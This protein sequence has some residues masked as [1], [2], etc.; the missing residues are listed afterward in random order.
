MHDHDTKRLERAASIVQENLKQLVDFEEL[1]PIW[2]RPGWT[3][4]AEFLLVE[5]M[6]NSLVALS[7]QMLEMKQIVLEGSRA[8]ISEKATVAD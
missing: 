8:V 6:M 5:G 4:P 7:G 1:I 2:R 3:T